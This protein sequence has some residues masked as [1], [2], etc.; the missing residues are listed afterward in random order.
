MGT[1]GRCCIV[2]QKAEDWLFNYH[3]IRVALDKSRIEPRYV[4][5]TI[6]ASADVEEYLSEKIRGATR[7]GVNS[8]IVGALPCRVPS[9]DEQRRIVA[10]LDNLQTKVDALK[11]LH[12]ETAAELD[13]MLPAILDA[14]FKG[15]L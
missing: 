7:Q 5:W 9:L 1:V 6:R 14:A 3:I 13:A 4:H 12:A 15:N 11:Q 2:P 8:T 10:Y